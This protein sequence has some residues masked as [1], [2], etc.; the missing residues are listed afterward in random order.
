MG[1]LLAISDIH[2]CNKTFNELLNKVALTSSDTLVITGDL[3]NRGP[4]S[5]GV[6]KTILT[7]L[8]QEFDIKVIRGNHEQM[9]LDAIHSSTEI[10][11]RFL[12]YY[13]SENLLSIK[14]K[15]KKKYVNF[16][17]NLPFYYTTDEYIFVHAA[18]DLS[19]ENIFDNI[20]F[21]LYSRYQKGKIQNLKG[22]T[23]I[24]GH[25]AT[26]FEIIK[27]NILKN[28]PIIGID[29]GCVYRDTKPEFGKLI[30]VDLKNKEI[31]Y[32]KN[33]D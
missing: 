22:K 23:L 31:Y 21:M 14:G 6:L 17:E 33:C 8:K 28:S 2:G 24:H 5:K 18:L 3:I 26:D 7:L 25:V 1:R 13:K 29:N 11:F 4:D 15:I 30:C 9:L 10:L 32:K 12:R 20:N 19:S 27:N 16:L